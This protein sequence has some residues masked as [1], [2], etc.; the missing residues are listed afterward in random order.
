MIEIMLSDTRVLRV[1]S[2]QWKHT[3][4]MFYDLSL[5]KM[6]KIT[7]DAVK[8]FLNVE[9]FSSSNTKVLHTPGLVEMLLH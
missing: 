8:K 6:R 9:N 5:K 3:Y 7:E 1:L 4:Q 2:M